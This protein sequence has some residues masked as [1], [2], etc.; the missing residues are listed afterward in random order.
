MTIEAVYE[1]YMSMTN[2]LLTEQTDPL[3]VAGVLMAQA[4]QLYKTILTEED[5]TKL[6]EK[7]M[8]SK[9]QVRKFTE[10][11]PKHVH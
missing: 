9:D 7:I 10:D 1:Q 4:M 3:Q 2:K 11:I 5:Y 6:L 8:S